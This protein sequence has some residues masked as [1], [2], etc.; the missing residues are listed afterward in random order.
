MKLITW[1]WILVA[2]LG[3]MLLIFI[4]IRWNNNRE[5]NKN[6]YEF[7]TSLSVQNVTT[8]P[9]IDTLIAVTLNKIMYY[10][11]MS[12]IVVKMPKL[13]TDKMD[14]IG[15][16]EED[17]QV[18]HQYY[19]YVDPQALRNNVEAFVVHEMIHLD[20]MESGRLRRV[21]GLTGK[22]FDGDTIDIMKVPYE[23]RA[24]EVE[25]YALGPDMVKKLDDLIYKH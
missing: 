13:S 5:S 9:Y 8:V 15:F 19:L 20:Q 12:V 10:D 25:A 14:L 11:S 21:S 7:P 4:G 17:P 22:I 18:K 2:V 6:V 3:M 24:F 1:L 23:Q 16:I